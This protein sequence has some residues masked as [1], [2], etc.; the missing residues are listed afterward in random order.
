R[1]NIGYP[2]QF[3][4]YKGVEIRDDDLYG[5]I[6]RA[7]A[8]NWRVKVRRLNGPYDRREGFFTP[9]SVNYAYIPTTNTPAIPAATL[10]PPFFDLKA[11]PALNY[12]AIGSLIG[13]M[14]V[15]GF[16]SQ[17][18]HYDADGRLRNWLTPE[19]TQ[20]LAAMTKAIADQ[21]SA[22]EPLPGLHLKGE[23]V[24]DEA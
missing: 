7:T 21:Y 4:D 18:V 1:V 24:A 5:D 12:G 16:D 6:Q 19:E 10:Q 14:F 20:K 2:D 23:L 3:Q 15:S 22:V 17:G 13:A 9:Q 11:D 8:Y